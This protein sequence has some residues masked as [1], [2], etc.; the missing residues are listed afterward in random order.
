MIDKIKTRIEELKKAREQT[1]Q[2]L[3]EYCAKILAPYNAA[4]GELE[5]LLPEEEKEQKNEQEIDGGS[6]EVG[7]SS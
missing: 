5:A 3:N 2:E 6:I 4:I 7:P 1:I